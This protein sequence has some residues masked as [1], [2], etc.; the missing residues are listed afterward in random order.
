[1]VTTWSPLADRVLLW[2]GMLSKPQRA[3]L[4]YIRRL[5]LTLSR[6]LLTGTC[7]SLTRLTRTHWITFRSLVAE[8]TASDSQGDGPSLP[9][10]ADTM[11]YYDL[12]D[13]AHLD[14]PYRVDAPTATLRQG[15]DPIVRLREEG[16]FG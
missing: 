3:E 14:P 11:D 10:L 2:T 6:S 7:R 9:P 5:P 16:D 4:P 8:A 13:E 15:C 1:M 12:T